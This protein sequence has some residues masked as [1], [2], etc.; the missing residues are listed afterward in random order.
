MYLDMIIGL[1][2]GATDFCFPHWISAMANAGH[3]LQRLCADTQS[4]VWSAMN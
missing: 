4:R 3:D 1:G 2:P